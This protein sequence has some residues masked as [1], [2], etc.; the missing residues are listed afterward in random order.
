MEGG[1]GRRGGKVVKGDA[2]ATSV[3]FETRL[4]QVL[5]IDENEEAIVAALLRECARIQRLR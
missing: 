3:V 2:S 1:G 4:H 5:K